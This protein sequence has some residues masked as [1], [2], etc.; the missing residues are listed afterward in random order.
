MN[1]QDWQAQRLD[2]RLPMGTVVA[3][4]DNDYADNHEMLRMNGRHSTVP[5]N[6]HP[7]QERDENKD[8]WLPL[9]TM[10]QYQQWIMSHGV[11]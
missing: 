10:P 5:L 2:R 7:E 9:N 8:A 11:V 3:G 6:N 1:C 4:K